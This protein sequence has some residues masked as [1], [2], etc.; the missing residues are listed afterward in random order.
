[1]RLHSRRAGRALE[2]K[3]AGT[4]VAICRYDPRSRGRPVPKDKVTD[5]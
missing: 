4:I 3:A 5:G 1:M 2:I